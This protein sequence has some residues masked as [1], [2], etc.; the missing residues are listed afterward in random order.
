MR[1]ND[2]AD[3]TILPASDGV[4][5]I[6]PAWLD[7]VALAPSETARTLSF[8]NLD[9]RRV[10]ANLPLD[11]VPGRGAVTADGRK[12]YLPLTDARRVA[13]FDASAGTAIGSIEAVSTASAYGICH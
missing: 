13:V 8:V 9:A 6:Y 4:R 3:A 5:V 11:G 10:T 2:P 12:F 1:D 7:A